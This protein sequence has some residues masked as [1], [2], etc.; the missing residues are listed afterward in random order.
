M[1][2]NKI[3]YFI[4]K[5]TDLLQP[6]Y[7][8]YLIYM[9]LY[10]QLLAICININQY[11][12]RELLIVLIWIPL[13]IIPYYLFK[14]KILYKILVIIFFIAGFINLTHWLLLKGEITASSLF[15][16]ANTNFSEASEFMSLKGSFRLFF[17]IPYIFLFI[18]ALRKYPSLIY[19]SVSKY[20][21][22]FIFIFITIYFTDNIINNR[23]LRKAVPATSEAIIYFTQEMKA[24]RLVKYR[25]VKKISAELKCKKNNIFVLILGESA[26][27]NHMSL[28]HYNRK[29]NP[30]LEKRNDIFM[31][32]NVITSHSNTIS[33]V[34]RM[35]TNKNLENQKTKENSI[36]L[37]DVFQSA[38]FQTYWISNQSP[39]GIWDNAVFDLAQTCN[40]IIFKNKQVNSSF[41][42]TTNFSFDE[43][44][45]EPFIKVLHEKQNNKFI[46]IHLM[47]SHSSYCKRYPASFKRFINFTNKKQKT[48]NEYDNSILYTDYIVNSIFSI[49]SQMAKKDTNALYSAIYLSDHGENV[50]DEM[51]NVGH[52]Y[53][54]IL[55]KSNVEIPFIVWLSNQYIK[56][57]FDKV[58]IIKKNKNTPF[59]TDDLFHAVLDIVNIQTFYFEKNRSLFNETYNINRKRILEDN[60]DYDL[61]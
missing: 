40:Q 1:P 42:S 47:G 50:Y 12:P 20:I 15:I 23:F 55:P 17:L 36:S 5:T 25:K 22:I 6:I 59:I 39:I 56:Y 53:N 45:I 33:S 52:N 8:I 54:G 18:I 44:L 37:I 2:D 19:H 3:Y 58:E 57:N 13:G 41:E 34:W 60:Q 30:L 14:K 16:L 31:Y 28:Y 32:T 29:T 24:S 43:I 10:I 35:F 4:K 46:V 21:T 61:K 9:L 26:S 38:D 51:D 48:I 7:P 27:R 11:N 49:L